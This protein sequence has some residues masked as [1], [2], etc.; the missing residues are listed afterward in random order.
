MNKSGTLKSLKRVTLLLAISGLAGCATNT[1]KE[2]PKTEES[3]ELYV[4]K[5][6]QQSGASISQHI[7]KVS[8]TQQA[9]LEDQGYIQKAHSKPELRTADKLNKRVT[10]NWNG[11]VEPLLES[12]SEEAGIAYYKPSGKAPP[13]PVTVSINPN[14]ESIYSVLEEIGAQLGTTAILRL[15]L[16]NPSDRHLRLIYSGVRGGTG[17][18]N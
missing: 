8:L 2:E 1:P 15:S 13:W 12:L 14:G 18:Y 11:P 3:A 5:A 17:A 9:K 4:L 16:K 7:A 6:L 10:F